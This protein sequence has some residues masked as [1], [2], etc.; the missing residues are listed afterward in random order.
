MHEVINR[1]QADAQKLASEYND[2]LI[3]NF[4]EI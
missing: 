1:I 3:G 2:K 4:F